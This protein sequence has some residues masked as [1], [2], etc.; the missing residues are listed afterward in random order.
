VV[1]RP[2]HNRRAKYGLPA[3]GKNG[4]GG[5]QAG[6]E[7]QR[8][9]VEPRHTL[10]YRKPIRVSTMH[11]HLHH[12]MHS[13]AEKFQGPSSARADNG[14][15]FD[16]MHIRLPVDAGGSHDPEACRRTADAPDVSYDFAMSRVH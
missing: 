8:V 14:R 16:P 4:S 10:Q 6:T 1:S 9:L 12:F 7:L 13:T 11:H 2:G 3:L 15:L 5:V